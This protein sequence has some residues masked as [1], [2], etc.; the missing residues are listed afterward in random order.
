MDKSNE[1]KEEVVAVVSEPVIIATPT[2]TPEPA[3][4]PSITSTDVHVSAPTNSNVVSSTESFISNKITSESASISSTTNTYASASNTYSSNSE[5]NFVAKGDAKI[6]SGTGIYTYDEYNNKF[7]K[8]G[9]TVTYESSTTTYSEPVREARPV[10]PS[11]IYDAPSSNLIVG[12]SYK[13]QLI[14]VEYHNPSHRR[15]DGVRNLGLEMDTEY[16]QEKGWTRVLMG[17]FKTEAEAKASL[18]NARVNGFKKAFIVEYK[19]GQRKR[20]IR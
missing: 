13:V 9:G 14:T 5:V 20:R 2:P 6:P 18:D 1:V 12:T 16:L 7:N 15:Y 4:K 10:A 19:D 8:K 3:P 11:V 17:S